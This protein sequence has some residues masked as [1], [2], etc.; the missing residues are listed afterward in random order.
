MSQAELEHRENGDPLFE[1]FPQRQLDDERIEIEESFSSG[2]VYQGSTSADNAVY[3]KNL[4]R[5]LQFQKELFIL[6]DAL[7]NLEQAKKFQEQT[8]CQG[9]AI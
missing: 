1:I 2:R 6:E 8:H 9:D 3:S 5:A 4:T 7:I